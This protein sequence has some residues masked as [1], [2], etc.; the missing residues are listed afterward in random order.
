MHRAVR[1]GLALAVVV[2]LAVPALVIGVGPGA[3]AAAVP[4]R[5]AAACGPIFRDQLAATPWPLR[6]L[7]PD[8]A[9]PL[10]RG[11]GV[12]VA[13]ID[14]GV[15]VD[16]PKLADRVLAGYD[17]LNKGKPAHCD[18][19]G[20]GTLVAA[21]IAGRDSPESPFHGIAPDAKILPIR[22]LPNAEETTDEQLP[23][24]IADAI[25]W[26]TDHGADII[27]LSLTTRDTNDVEQAVRYAV[28]RDVV[29]VAAAGN[30]GGSAQEGQAVY[31]AAYRDV[32][33]VAGVDQNDARVSTSN[34]G[35]YVDVAAPGLA[36]EGPSTRGRGYV[37][38]AKG[39]TSFAAA[40]VSGV[41][42][43]IRASYPRLPASEVARRIKLTA[44]APP[45]GRND[46][47][48]TGVVNPYQAVAAILDDQD[49]LVPTETEQLAAP[50]S[51]IDPLRIVRLVG[52]GG[53]VA[54]AAVVI[55]LLVL[56]P[57]LRA[58]RRRQHEQVGR[59]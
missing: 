14:S 38:D 4:D 25:T 34:A 15:S 16:H 31:P 8:V 17:Y 7:Q 50:T 45:G 5:R 30:T 48:G 26:A 2:G 32:I 11:R 39:G 54:A 1:R 53:A 47:V 33:A 20:H 49:R 24:R 23:K 21:I 44:D 36:I 13:V 10:S 18:E 28:N 9:W 35:D 55:V 3:A 56:M 42:A 22:V 27:N 37:I 57:G 52:I 6:R 59:S 12:T 46:E 41:A 51:A 58:A 43:L 29:V 19:H 40:Y